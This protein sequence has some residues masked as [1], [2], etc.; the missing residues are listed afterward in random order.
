[1]SFY[2]IRPRAG[3]AAQWVLANPVLG[4]RE[5]GVEVPPEGI[6][7][8]LVKIKFGDGATAWNDLPYGVLPPEI[9]IDDLIAQTLAG[10][11][12]DKAPSVAAVAAAF[13]AI[14]ATIKYDPEADMIQ[15]KDANGDWVDWASAGLLSNVLYDN[16]VQYVQFD[17]GHVWRYNS[18]SYKDSVEEG[19]SINIT[20]TSSAGSSVTGT[21]D[22]IDL[23]GY[24]YLVYEILNNSVPMKLEVDVSALSGLYYVGIGYRYADAALAY[25]ATSTKNIGT[26]AV[27]VES[28]AVASHTTYVR[29]IYLRK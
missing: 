17:F 26:G 6:G 2:R 4:E 10:K 14:P 28:K 9:D 24:N 13:E 8:G 29:K 18:Y 21:S 3:T 19:T 5:I 12:T 23:T 16:G 22:A 1:M 11:E 25:G 20:G 15:L 7:K 27:K